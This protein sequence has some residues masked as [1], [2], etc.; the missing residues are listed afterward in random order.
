MKIDLVYLRLVLPI[1]A[2]GVV[3]SIATAVI[4]PALIEKTTLADARAEALG[5]V[6][7]YRSMRALYVSAVVSKVTANTGK[8]GS[9][10]LT[11]KHRATPNGV[12]IPATFL[13]DAVA[14]K[15]DRVLFYSPYPFAARQDRKLDENQ[16]K[17]WELVRATPDD[18]FVAVVP[19]ADGR[20]I[21]RVATADKLPAQACADCHNRHPDRNPNVTWQWNVGDVRGVLEARVDIE[22]RLMSAQRFGI[23]VGG[24]IALGA[25]AL[26][27]LAAWIARRTIL[28]PVNQIA[29]AIGQNDKDLIQSYAGSGGDLGTLARTAHRALE[30]EERR[31]AAVAAEQAASETHRQLVE[32]QRQRLDLLKSDIST[33]V[34]QAMGA[35]QTL[36]STADETMTAAR[37]QKDKSGSLRDATLS[38]AS[39]LT[40][41]AQEA[42]QLDRALDGGVEIIDREAARADLAIRAAQDAVA[43]VVELGQATQGIMNAVD[44]IR[45]IAKQTNLLALN[46]TIEAARAGDAGKGFI[47]VAG[48]VKHLAA[49]SAETSSEI[50]RTVSDIQQRLASATGAIQTI[51]TE[52]RSIHHAMAEVAQ[53]VTRA[54][55]H[56]A[57]ASRAADQAVTQGESVTQESAEI[58][59]L[60]SRLG[61]AMTSVAT[62]GAEVEAV[63]Q[64][65]SER[66]DRF[67]SS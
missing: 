61:A 47:I 28:S 50:E 22:D 56:G 62:V 3:A 36:K 18:A 52:A 11:E 41:L 23:T 24:A 25:L 42:R 34:V 48:E 66:L 12:P 32:S 20:R 49:Q 27:G 17:A 1:V 58:D 6:A 53:E 33:M 4:L 21:M 10:A 38:S 57:D 46:A 59:E 30:D 65:M 55:G 39:R 9:L 15:E 60:A 43:R 8:E 19:N 51:E 31:A 45:S 67:A 13:L 29:S 40:D 63:I 2:A 44:A 37:L 7:D 26:A 14:G 64:A 54:R 5:R 16:L 35:V